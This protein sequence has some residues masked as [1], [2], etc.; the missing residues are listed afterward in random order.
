[1]N[2]ES[3]QRWL[4][5]HC[6]SQPEVAGGIVLWQQH[7]VVHQTVAEFPLPG[8][9]T[10]GL[11]SVA[12]EAA[13]R[14]KSLV[15]VPAVVQKDAGHARVIAAP[16]R[17]VDGLTIGA[18]ALA[19]KSSNPDVAKKLLEDLERVSVSLAATLAALS[20]DAPAMASDRLLKLQEIIVGDERLSGAALK[21]ANHLASEFHFDRVAVS[22][23][24]RGKLAIAGLSHGQGLDERQE[25]VRGIVDAMTEATDQ[26]AT[27]TYPTGLGDV[28]RIS[29]SHAQLAARTG[30]SLC[31]VPLNAAG[32]VTGALTFE[33]KGT[34]ALT[35]SDKA[36]CEQVGGAIA[37]MLELKRQA[38]KSWWQRA[39]DARLRMWSSRSARNR[40]LIVGGVLLLLLLLFLIP[41]RFNVG[42][43]ARVEGAVQR[44]IAAPMDGYLRSTRVRP[45][46]TVRTGDVLVELA[47]QELLLDKRRLE[48]ELSRHQNN[49]SA[50]M[51]RSDRALFAVNVSRAA[52]TKAQLDLVEAQLARAQVVAPMDALV[53]QGDLTQMIGAP[54][55]RGDTLL[56][57]APRDQYRVMIDG[58]ERDIPYIQLGQ[59]GRLAL[60]A[61]PGEALEFSVQRITPVATISRDGRNVFEVEAKLDAGSAL[62]RHGL[63]GVAKIESGRHTL[64]WITFRRIVGWLRLGIWSW[65]P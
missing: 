61:L 45:G 65:W 35:E 15:L 3:V 17:T 23:I 25:L 36:L 59:R 20:A 42:A 13:R 11:V 34:A 50:A 56:T 53:I 32:R 4:A 60:A 54:V 40:N 12:K 24:T 8:A 21:L 14:A 2:F 47:D 44:V 57:L 22:V 1:M 5:G 63:Q 52:E 7:E 29:Q 9:Y 48:S 10:A 16:V 26:N 31:T 27:V 30:T 43:S 37:P 55:K 64:A 51:G 62:P 28:P 19:V 33:R 18:V 6:E 46:D 49:F 38:D 58:D 39:Q 41:M